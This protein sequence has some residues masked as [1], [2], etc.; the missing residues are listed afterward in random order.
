M[1]LIPKSQITELIPLFIQK[2]KITEDQINILQEYINN[3]R[4][5]GNESKQYYHLRD[6]AT[7]FKID[8]YNSIE[9]DMPEEK[10]M[11]T[12]ID[13]SGQLKKKWLLTRGG[14]YRLM[15]N[16]NNNIGKLLRRCI[17]FIFNELFKK[18][19][20]TMQNIEEFVKN[21]HLSLYIQTVKDL[22]RNIY[23]LKKEKESIERRNIYLEDFLED[24]HNQ[25]EVIRSKV[26]NL[27]MDK[28]SY[29]KK[30]KQITQHIEILKKE[31]TDDVNIINRKKL[32]IISKYT[33]TIFVY[34][35][36]ADNILLL[37]KKRVNGDDEKIRKISK[38]L[39]KS[40]I[41]DYDMNNYDINSPPYDDMIM[42]FSIN[43]TQY[44][45]T[46][47]IKR[48]L[49]LKIDD[50]NKNSTYNKLKEFLDCRYPLIFKKKQNDK[51]KNMLICSLEEIKYEY[52]LLSI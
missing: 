41:D 35:E 28:I 46:S 24:S 20:V 12:I 21:D 5:Y 30:N 52:Q 6:V 36:S 19:Y 49:V 47:K 50:I 40:G 16:S 29:V 39:S 23:L 26:I 3:I 33:K 8:D 42:I 9:F 18:K 27:E 25:L 43:K 1:Q 32:A 34:L 15:Y 51:I 2:K 4:I 11:G 31:S 14:L 22:H 13:K 38:M 45:S 17:E 48:V 7:I 37:S 44:P 10:F